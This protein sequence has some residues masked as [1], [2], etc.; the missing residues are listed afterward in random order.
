MCPETLYTDSN[1]TNDDGNA[2]NDDA[3]SQLH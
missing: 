1:D 3:T 2:D